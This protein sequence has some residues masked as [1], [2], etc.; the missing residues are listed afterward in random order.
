MKSLCDTIQSCEGLTKRLVF[1]AT[2]NPA[3]LIQ[4]RCFIRQDFLKMIMEHIHV[5]T[6]E[7]Q[8]DRFEKSCSIYGV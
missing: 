6:K 1:L 3:K 7:K 5:I 8:K 2:S 4:N